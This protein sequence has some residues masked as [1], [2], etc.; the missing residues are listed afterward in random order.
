[1][2]ATV[3]DILAP[4]G[5]IAQHLETY[6]PRD[7]QMEM[8]EA[9]ADAFADREHLLAE[10]GTGVGKSFAYLVPAILHVS[11]NRKPKT[12]AVVSTFTIALQEQIIRK[13]LPFLAEVMPQPFSA[14]LGK[15]RGNYLCFRRLALAAKGRDRLLSSETQQQQLDR[16]ADWAMRTETGEL[17]EIDFP[18]APAVW[19]R[20]RSDKNLCRGQSCAHHSRCFLQAA[21]RKLLAA[22]IVVVN[23]AMFFADLALR[24]GQGNLLGDYRLVVLD[25]AHTVEAVAGDHFG[26]SV[27]SAAVGGLLRE[28]YNAQSHRGLLALM[29]ANE[30][31][32][33]IQNATGAAEGFFDALAA[34][35][36]P[37]VSH[38]GRILQADIVPD[39]LAPPLR[40]AAAR[41]RT[42]R[43]QCENEEQAFELSA[44]ELRLSETAEQLERLLT[45]A[46]DDHA[47]WVTARAG[48]TQPFVTLNSAPIHVAPILRAQLFDKTPSIVLTSATLATARAGE[49][50][51]EYLRR[52]LGVD[53]AREVLLAS[54]FNFRRQARLYLETRLGDPN[55][56][57]RFAPAA[58]AAARH[59][60]AESQGRCFLLCTS[61]AMLHALA[62][63]LEDFCDAHDYEL[64]VQGG[65]LPR[66]AMLEQFREKPRCVLAGTMSFWQGVDVAGEALSNV[67]IAKLPFAAPDSPMIEARIDA[68]RQAGGNPFADYQLPQA[69][70]LFKQGFGRLIRST[71]DTGFVVVLDHRIATKFYGRA[72]LDALPDI[73]I[74][75]DEFGAEDA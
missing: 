69:V 39:T 17:Q 12:R 44:Y 21:R 65:P 72:F 49:H 62:D 54:P 63:E 64:L 9:V 22:D 18:L 7:E 56:L 11:A 42:L 52:R 19:N 50:G 35:H 47:Y 51:F 40:A 36:G 59:Y 57:A 53:E 14:E 58:G 24:A 31:I 34:I 13:D 30:A 32:Q 5:R 75:W 43:R 16:L 6:E 20:V 70:I 27:S 61:Y 41:L 66:S 28:L 48:R 26:R 68:I 2:N 37:G 74:V 3:S 60:I 67:I 33:A 46:D 45:Q 1:V 23:H 8:A 15:G 4:G 73:E 55:D 25:E 71:T 29:Q 10:A 38:S